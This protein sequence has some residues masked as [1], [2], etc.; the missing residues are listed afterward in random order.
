[1]L[2]EFYC[3][4]SFLVQCKS[5][6][7]NE[8]NR[9]DVMLSFRIIILV[10]QALLFVETLYMWAHRKKEDP[11]SFKK[12]RAM[13]WMFITM[14]LIALWYGAFR[15]NHTRF[16]SVNRMD[17]DRQSLPVPELHSHF[18]FIRWLFNDLLRYEVD[19]ASPHIIRNSK[20][21]CKLTGRSVLYLP[22]WFY[23]MV[24]LT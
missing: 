4:G 9:Y 21:W 16:P 10:F 8:A 14:N 23:G 24:H 5:K 12:H 11:K 18:P 2:S 22:G 19:R 1:M 7:Q 17:T 3:N 13:R 6:S 20:F 15:P